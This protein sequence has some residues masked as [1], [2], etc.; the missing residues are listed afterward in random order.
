[1]TG[2]TVAWISVSVELAEALD[3]LEGSFARRDYLATLQ[4]LRTGVPLVANDGESGLSLGSMCRFVIAS[5]PTFDES[6]WNARFADVLAGEPF[7]Q[8]D[9]DDIVVG[10]L[11]REPVCDPDTV[12]C[13]AT[14]SACRVGICGHG[15]HLGETGRLR[16]TSRAVPSTGWAWAAPDRLMESL[17]QRH[18]F[19]QGFERLKPTR[20]MGL[21]WALSWSRSRQF[22]GI[23]KSM[24]AMPPQHSKTTSGDMLAVWLLAITGGRCRLLTASHSESLALIRGAFVRQVIEAAP[25]LGV[26]VDAHDRAKHRW[27]TA[28][29]HGVVL[30]G[31]RSFGM[32]SRISGVPA[33]VVIV[34]DPADGMA[35]AVGP[36]SEAIWERWTSV[37]QPRLQAHSM[38][39]VLGT[40]WSE[41]D[42]AGRLLET[43]ADVW[44]RITVPALSTGSSDDPLGRVG[45]GIAA[46]PRRFTALQLEERRRTLGPVLFAAVFQ[47]DPNAMGGGMFD[48]AMWGSVDFDPVDALFFVRAWDLAGGGA[49]AT[50]AVLLAVTGGGQ[51]VIADILHERLE[52]VDVRRRLVEVSEADRDTWGRH[53]AVTQV[54][55]QQPGA[56]GKDQALT[57]SELVRGVE[58]MAPSG[59]KE[60]RAYAASARQLEG[61][62]YISES[63]PKSKIDELVRETD[64]FPGGRH[65]DLC[66]ALAYAINWAL[67]RARPRRRARIITPAAIRIAS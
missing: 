43:E 58:F 24:L 16:G 65:D 5:D 52:V 14:D 41:S 49:D 13:P 12:Q 62:L 50:A 21:L 7:L 63:I 31:L 38:A 15:G 39:T 47:Q 57:I 56:S 40:R 42:L 18:Q 64:A 59:S 22:S 34:D 30:G 23:V 44:S 20:L 46:E 51:L 53:A 19:I 48:R 36:N 8:S 55:E 54:V 3:R 25:E 1:M 9:P 60:A 61:D 33:D 27:R 35:E 6:P 67:F 45:A 32:S 10:P 26:R 37:L 4:L 2:A 66:D 17:C 29:A 28:D 11:R